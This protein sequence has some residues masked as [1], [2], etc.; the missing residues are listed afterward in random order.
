MRDED[1]DEGLA[2]HKLEPA[3]VRG[4]T[5]QREAIL[6]DLFRHAHREVN[7]R[8]LFDRALL[9]EGRGE[10]RGRDIPKDSMTH[11]NHTVMILARH[12]TRDRTGD[13][14]PQFRR[15]PRAQTSSAS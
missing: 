2:H 13:V 1:E 7:H 15:L 6:R 3:L 11:I 5:A 4:H 12:L 8:L 14:Q 10:K 9:R